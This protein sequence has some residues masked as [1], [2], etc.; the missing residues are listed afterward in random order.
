MGHFG[1]IT[2]VSRPPP[3]KTLIRYIKNAMALN[4]QE[5]PALATAIEWMAEGKPRNWKYM[6]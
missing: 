2:S 1:R 4:E 3:R 5:I 6:E